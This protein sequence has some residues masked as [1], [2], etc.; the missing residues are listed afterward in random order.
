MKRKYFIRNIS[1]YAI[2]GGLGSLLIIG[3]SGC[4]NKTQTNQSN[5]TIA[6]ASD[7]KNVFVV[8]EK[9]SDGSYKIIDEF[10]STNTTIVLR[11]NGSER[12]LSKEEIDKLVKEEAVK[13]DNNTS[14]LTK[15]SI[16]SGGMSLGETL[17]ASAAGAIIGAYIGNK[18]FNNSNYENQR[19]TNYKSPQTYSK[20]VNSF[21]KGP[22]NQ[23]VN[24]KSPQSN[25]KNGFFSNTNKSS[26]NQSNSFGG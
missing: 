9:S 26:S 8:I 24:N 11:E 6:Q 18:L 1:N 22:A 16:S 12:I 17:L 15:E 25:S 3:L 20:S 14:N 21:N 4:E 2:V 23:S 5:E 13:I 7:K 10:P 19:R